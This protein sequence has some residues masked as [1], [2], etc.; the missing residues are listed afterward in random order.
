MKPNL[1]IYVH[2]PFCKSKCPYCDFNSHVSDAVNHQQWRKSYITEINY[3][4]DYI[5]KHNI[6]SIFFGGGTPTLMEPL[7]VESIINH[8]QL[9]TGFTQD[10]EITLEGN[11]TSVEAAKLEKFK[12][13]GINRVSLG[14]QSLN[15]QDLQFLGREH[16]ANEAMRA[17]DAAGDI[18]ENYSFDLI[19]ARPE[20]TLQG[21]ENELTEALKIA[22]NHISLYQLTIEKGTRF[23]SDYSKG[24]F[25]IPDEDLAADFYLLTRQ[26]MEAHGMPAYEISNHA[27]SG[28]ESRHNMSYWRYDDYLGIG[29]G[30]HGRITQK[31]QKHAI[32]MFSKPEAWLRAIA[33]QNNAMQVNQPLNADEVIDEIIMMGLRVREGVSCKRFSS[34]TGHKI[35]ERISTKS[36]NKLIENQLVSMNDESIKCTESGMLLVNYIASEL[37]SNTSA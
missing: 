5:K 10:I 24:A 7:T 13:A 27:R 25:K 16:S 32:M 11:P 2:W 12:H 28:F 35:E 26:I 36:L 19:Y 22:G 20:Q 31:Q 37:L 1:A 3:F 30:A 9:L 8:L 21:W 34:I 29:P 6:S 23:F 17:V 18:F 4:A 15:A 33:E 14:V